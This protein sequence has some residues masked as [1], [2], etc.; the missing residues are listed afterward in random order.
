M[1]EIWFNETAQFIGAVGATTVRELAELIHEDD[2][3][4]PALQ[5]DDDQDV[6]IDD[7]ENAIDHF[8]VEVL[9]IADDVVNDDTWPDTAVHDATLEQGPRPGS[10][11][12]LGVFI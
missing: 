4:L 1:A 6:T 7:V 2:A 10:T 3:V 9:D 12:V 11:R 5:F 8:G